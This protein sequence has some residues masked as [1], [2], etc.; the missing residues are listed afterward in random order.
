MPVP[1]ADLIERLGPPPSIVC[2]D[3]MLQIESM[4]A[5]L[6]E[7]DGPRR[8]DGSH[9]LLDSTASAEASSSQRH[10][11]GPAVAGPSDQG[12]EERTNSAAA[13]AGGEVSLTEPDRLSKH[14]HWTDFEVLEDGRL[15]LLV[16]PT[17]A[18]SFDSILQQLQK[19][20]QSGPAGGSGMPAAF[21]SAADEQHSAPE[22]ASQRHADAA[23]HDRSTP[24]GGNMR[25]RAE[26][27]F[28]RASRAAAGRIAASD[29]AIEAQHRQ[30]SPWRL[31]TGALGVLGGGGALALLLAFAFWPGETSAPHRIAQE[32]S[33][34]LTEPEQMRPA[35]PLNGLEQR[36][37]PSIPASLSEQATA[38]GA[39]E[40]LT[41]DLDD[42]H[43]SSSTPAPSD[44]L[45]SV[46]PPSE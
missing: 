40:L 32:R 41:L 33:A 5:T 10:R 18:E 29:S 20:L 31:S 38:T 16:R 23:D 28:P 37:E 26:S 39:E 30:G 43:A 2:E 19:W 15:R 36:S 24:T 46:L 14:L 35:P 45:G 17:A 27:S 21:G 7:Q 22:P 12:S 42:L 11:V 9:G 6:R 44:L 4:V 34:V 25:R 1:A 3:W 8:D 13:D